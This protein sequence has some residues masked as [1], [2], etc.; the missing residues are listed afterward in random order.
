MPEEEE[1]EKKSENSKIEKSTENDEKTINH[2]GLIFEKLEASQVSS[3]NTI[4]E[5][6]V[7]KRGRPEGLLVYGNMRAQVV[8]SPM[9]PP[10]PRDELESPLINTN[11]TSLRSPRK[12]GKE[13]SILDFLKKTL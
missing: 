8:E 12:N 6:S 1:N 11:F 13:I 7:K 3:V 10:N 2:N 9:L 5:K 4:S